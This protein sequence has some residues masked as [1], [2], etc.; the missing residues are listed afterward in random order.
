MKNVAKPDI[1]KMFAEAISEGKKVFKEPPTDDLATYL[2][3]ISEE[4]L[5]SLT[6]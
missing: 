4:G 5:E 1:A 3:I 2:S 6:H